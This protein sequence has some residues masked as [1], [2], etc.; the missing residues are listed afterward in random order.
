MASLITI[1]SPRKLIP[2]ETLVET[3]CQKVHEVN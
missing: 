3:L 2:D 1:Y